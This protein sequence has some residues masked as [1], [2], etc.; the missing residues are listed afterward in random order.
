MQFSFFGVLWNA[1]LGYCF[2]FKNGKTMAYMAIISMLFQC[3]NILYIG[4]TGIGTQIFTVCIASVKLLLVKKD[5]RKV[6]GTEP[7]NVSF[8]MMLGVIIIGLIYNHS[9]DGKHMIAISMLAVYILFG[10]ILVKKQIVFTQAELEKMINTVAYVIIIVGVLQVLC[11][12][13][14]LPITA[15][16]RSFIYNDTGNSN[17]IFNHKSITAMY[18]TFMEPSYCGATLTGLLACV[19]SRKEFTRKNLALVALLGISILMTRSST[20]YAGTAIMLCVL[21]FTKAD[22]KIYKYVMPLI[23]VAVMFIAIFNMDLLNEVLFEKMN[24]GSF[25]VRENWNKMALEKFFQSPVLGVGYQNQRASSL[26]YTI[27]GELGIIGAFAYTM[28]MIAS[29]KFLL[30]KKYK[31]I[32]STTS[33][34]CFGIALSQWIACPDLSFSPMWMSFYFLILS[35][36][37]DKCAVGD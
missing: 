12:M 18:S 13:N 3:N 9:L 36:K 10:I 34:M 28:M 29:L 14:I 35:L 11:K 5:P 25:R 26:L 32:V 31:G 4:T 33:F 20:A 27:L 17:V 15:L 22:K 7:L 6:Y 19:I 24:T 37:R 2:L 1:I 23:I 30:Q 21:L 16:L 8:I